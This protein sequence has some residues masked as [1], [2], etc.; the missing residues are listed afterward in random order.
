M[1]VKDLIKVYRGKIRLAKDL[2]EFYISA[3]E[4]SK[5]PSMYF[6]YTV[7]S[8]E[9][10]Y[11]WLYVHILDPKINMTVD[12]AL[13]KSSDKEE[14]ILITLPYNGEDSA[15][16]SED[17]PPEYLYLPISLL[18]EQEDLNIIILEV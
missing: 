17:I 13:M 8:L 4:P 15:F 11:E 3:V 7:S 12:A 5:I 16:L 9:F 10:R 14:T 2:N 6:N 1:K 18:I